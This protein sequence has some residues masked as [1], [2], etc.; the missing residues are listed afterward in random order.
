MKIRHRKTRYHH[1]LLDWLEPHIVEGRRIRLVEDPDALAGGSQNLYYLTFLKD[2]PEVIE[3]KRR[4][5]KRI[6]NFLPHHGEFSVPHY[7]DDLWT[8]I[9]GKSKPQYPNRSQYVEWCKTNITGYWAIEDSPLLGNTITVAF[10]RA[11]DLVMF[12]L[13]FA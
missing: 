1:R 11:E 5:R 2:K 8:T 13:A 9:L 4:I 10:G 3:Q 7:L 12:K 6:L